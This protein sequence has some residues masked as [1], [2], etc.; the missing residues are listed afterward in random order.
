VWDEQPA[1]Y[2]WISG[3]P[4]AYQLQLEDA[5]E[6]ADGGVRGVF[7]I[8][9]YPYPGT[10]AYRGFSAE[11]RQALESD[12][13]DHTGTPAAE[14]R[15]RIPGHLFNVAVL[16][17]RV[18]SDGHL[19]QLVLEGLDRMVVRRLAP[20]VE[21]GGATRSAEVYRSVPAWEIAY[22]FFDRLVCLWVHYR[23]QRPFDVRLTRASGFETV[24]ATDEAPACRDTETA[25]V[26]TLQVGFAAPGPF[27]TLPPDR[28]PET[29]G[30]GSAVFEYHSPCGHFHPPADPVPLVDS[31]NPAWWSLA[32]ARFTCELAS[33]CGCDHDH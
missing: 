9:C 20:I 19:S 21:G 15:E 14:A 27:S 24:L 22:P 5:T 6:E 3:A 31:L 2:F 4:G 25:A 18:G 10:A 11:E 32:D 1:W 13:F 33:T 26:Y 30:A 7:S 12:L 16:E 17:C 28:R 8:K 29:G 23:R